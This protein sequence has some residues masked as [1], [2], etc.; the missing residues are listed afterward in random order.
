[1]SECVPIKRVHTVTHA[2]RGADHNAL[3][4]LSYLRPVFAPRLKG[5]DHIGSA[6]AIDAWQHSAWK[7]VAQ[8]GKLGI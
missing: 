4:R 8:P 5:W 3:R 1:M 2:A 6:S 7:R